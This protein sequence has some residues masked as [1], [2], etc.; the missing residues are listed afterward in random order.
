MELPVAVGQREQ[1]FTHLLAGEPDL[2]SINVK[3]SKPSGSSQAQKIAELEERIERL[4]S[5]LDMSWSNKEP[6]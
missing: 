4:E 6:D 1:R 3:V 2:S 5:A